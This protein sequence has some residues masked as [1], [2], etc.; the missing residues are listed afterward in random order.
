MNNIK[1]CTGCGQLLRQSIE[2]RCAV[3]IRGD[4]S[5]KQ[6]QNLT[7][8]YLPGLFEES[9]FTTYI[10]GD[11]PNRRVQL[12]KAGRCHNIVESRWVLQSE[13]ERLLE[14][15]TVIGVINKEYPKEM[16]I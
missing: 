3:C 4:Y 6:K 9:G 7:F 13:A 2:N 5:I 8:E 11:S 10:T 15:L 14:A 12:F 16:R 1:R